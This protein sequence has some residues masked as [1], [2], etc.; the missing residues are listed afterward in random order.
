MNWYL[1]MI[2]RG[3]NRSEN[4]ETIMSMSFKIAC[5]SEQLE[6]AHDSFIAFKKQIIPMEILKIVKFVS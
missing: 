5:L 1:T 3:Y 6:H 2:R 4:N